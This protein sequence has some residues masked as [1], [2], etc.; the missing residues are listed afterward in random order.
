MR[1]GAQ[2]STHNSDN[3]RKGAQEN[4]HKSAPSGT[5]TKRHEQSKSVMNVMNLHEPS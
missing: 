4:A 5:V 1:N 3:M 2:K